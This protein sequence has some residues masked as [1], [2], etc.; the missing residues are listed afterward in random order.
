ML[1]IIKYHDICRYLWYFSH[2]LMLNSCYSI[3]RLLFWKGKAHEAAVV[4]EAT[5]IAIWRGGEIIKG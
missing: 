3:S 4:V 5:H 2:Y 1:D